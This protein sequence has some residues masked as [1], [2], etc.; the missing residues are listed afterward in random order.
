MA[1]VKLINIRLNLDNPL[2]F[3]VWNYLQNLEHKEFKSYSD[4]ATKAIADYFDRYYSLKD[5]PFLETRSKED[6]FVNKIVDAVER[7]LANTLP[8]F[9]LSC[10]VANATMK[11]PMSEENQSPPS[12]STEIDWNFLGDD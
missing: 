5:D 6:D 4:A 12:E 11:M 7:N 1:N 9:M 2:H 10:L 3:K 8:E